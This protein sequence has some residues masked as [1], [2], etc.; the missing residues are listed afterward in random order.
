MKLRNILLVSIPLIIIFAILTRNPTHG[1][2]IEDLREGDIL[3]GD[4]IYSDYITPNQIVSSAINHYIKW[5]EDNLKIYKYDGKD[6]LNNHRWL[7][8]LNTNEYATL[9]E[10]EINVLEIKRYINETLKKLE[11]MTDYELK[12]NSSYQHDSEYY[13]YV[14]DIKNI[15]ISSTKNIY[16]HIVYKEKEILKNNLEIKKTSELVIDDYKNRICDEE[17]IKKGFITYEDF[18]AVGDGVHNDAHA[19]YYAHLCANKLKVPVKSYKKTY[20]ISNLPVIDNVIKSI[21]I[22]TNV[23]WNNSTIILDDMNLSEKELQTP[24]FSISPMYIRY[25]HDDGNEIDTN[26]DKSTTK[27]S[28]LLEMIESGIEKKGEEYNSTYYYVGLTSTTDK[29]YRS[30]GETNKPSGDPRAKSDFFKIDKEGNV[31]NEIRY[32]YKGKTKV[33]INVVPDKTLEIKN[34][35]FKHYAPPCVDEKNF[36]TTTKNQ[37]QLKVARS[38]VIIDNINHY[39]ID[40]DMPTY[41]GSGFLS[42]LNVTDLTIKNSNFRAH[43]IKK[44]GI[45]GEAGGSYDISMAN[46]ANLTY[47]NLGYTCNEGES[48][49]ECYYKNIIDSDF[50]GIVGNN[51][52]KNWKIKNSILNRIDSHEPSINISV[53]NSILGH[54]SVNVTGAGQ[55]EILNSSIDQSI[56]IVN[57]RGDY[58]GTWNGNIRLNNIYFNTRNFNGR[59]PTSPRILQFLTTNIFNIENGGFG[60]DTFVPSIDA[61]NIFIDEL[62]EINSRKEYPKVEYNNKYPGVILV[63]NTATTTINDAKN[64]VLKST[65]VGDMNFNNIRSVALDELVIGSAFIGNT[66]SSTNGPSTEYVY[67]KDGEIKT[68]TPWGVERFNRE[69]F[70]HN[71]TPININIDMSSI[72]DRKFTNYYEGVYYDDGVEKSKNNSVSINKKSNSHSYCTILIDENINNDWYR[73]KEIHA[74]LN[75]Y[76]PDGISIED[77]G[78]SDNT[79]TYNKTETMQLTND[80]V[81]NIYGFI[82]D[83]TGKRY[84]CIKLIKKSS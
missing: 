70:Y 17:F 76:T 73:D 58:G 47:E 33:M 68:S 62:N 5:K 13:I 66:N 26:Y 21:P 84:D 44:T 53:E 71:T 61:A 48:K 51:N 78:L 3:I 25:G 10:E 39:M 42:A 11:Q 18:Y 12:N 75:L 63:Q 36:I 65:L 31:L 34:A 30:S 67:N 20:Y 60:Y 29:I 7:F 77:Y 50:F 64:G 43:R 6:L 4:E 40:N 32:D 14:D 79:I 27:V 56:S 83:S 72:T 80:G 23:D 52:I 24:V 16:G 59:Y 81:Y 9:S 49:E 28:E 8:L 74:K 35:N 1:Y 45:N 46:V 41:F 37:R 2:K 15:G 57:L 82:K 38:N 54:S 55:M 69:Y 22:E 19:I